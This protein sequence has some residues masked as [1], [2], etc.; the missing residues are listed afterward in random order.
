MV[1]SALNRPLWH[2]PDFFFRKFLSQG[3]SK[4]RRLSNNFL[5]TVGNMSVI[6]V[7][8]YRIITY[9]IFSGQADFVGMSPYKTFFRFSS[10]NSTG[11]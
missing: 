9:Y 6:R 2:V 5:N 7:Y 1:Q 8:Y 10:T 3:F 4:N 11:N